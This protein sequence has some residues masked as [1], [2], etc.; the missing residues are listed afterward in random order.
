MS[1]SSTRTL[2]QTK[3]YS[4]SQKGRSGQKKKGKIQSSSMKDRKSRDKRL[5]GSREGISWIKKLPR[6]SMPVSNQ[7]FSLWLLLQFIQCRNSRSN[8]VLYSQ[9]NQGRTL[10]W[11]S[12]IFSESTCSEY[13]WTLDF[14]SSFS[15]WRWRSSQTGENIYGQQLRTQQNSRSYL[16]WRWCTSPTSNQRLWKNQ[17][18]RICGLLFVQG[19]IWPSFTS[20]G[21]NKNGCWP[22]QLGRGLC[23]ELYVSAT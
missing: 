14:N 8:N 1:G 11:A 4:S 12:N 2:E 21:S 3:C 7:I 18:H 20:L 9:P 6:M 5:K 19:S 15:R 22:F 17:R 23:S 10:L 16:T 13:Q